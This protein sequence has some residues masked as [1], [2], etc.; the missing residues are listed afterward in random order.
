[1][2][3]FYAS[4][5]PVVPGDEEKSRWLYVTNCGY[6][7]GITEDSRT[8]RSVGRSDYHLIYCKSGRILTGGEVLTDGD[9]RIYAPGEPQDYTY[10][11]GEQTSY[12]WAHFVGTAVTDILARLEL[13]SG[14][15][16]F[17]DRTD[18]AEKLWLMLC[19][20]VGARQ[21]NSNDYAASLMLAALNLITLKK[22]AR[23]PF[24][25]AAALL[26]DFT[27]E[28]RV[29]ELAKRYRMSTGYFIESF[30]SVYGATP[31]NYRAAKQMEQAK[32]LLR[33]TDLSISAVAEMSA[34]SDPLYFS[35]RFRKYTGM[36]PTEFRR[37]TLSEPVE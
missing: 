11:A 7:R 28:V 20:V 27:A 14:I 23:L 35:R 34:F 31:M 33:D 21:N 10:A 5:N 9:F 17:N 24:S 37:S 19:D 22:P 4:R 13:E 15:Y 18:E 3:K 36:S 12:L 8:V 25:G 29:P 32:I 2:K 6:Y 1:M 30:K 26:E 16:H